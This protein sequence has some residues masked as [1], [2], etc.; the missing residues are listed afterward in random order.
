MIIHANTD[1]YDT[2]ANHLERFHVS[3]CIDMMKDKMNYYRY[4]I[5]LI[6]VLGTF[7]NMLICIG[8]VCIE[9]NHYETPELGIRITIS[10]SVFYRCHCEY[11]DDITYNTDMDN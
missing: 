11:I 3:A 5:K 9:N 1:M 7:T 8:N 6:K 4:I 10:K 2:K